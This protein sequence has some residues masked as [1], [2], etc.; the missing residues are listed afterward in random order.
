[1]SYIA[2]AWLSNFFYA[3]SIVVGKLSSKY[4]LRN[5]WLFNFVWTLVIVLGT[6]PFAI[7][8]GA[9]LPADWNSVFLVGIFSALAGTLYILSLY[10]L[11]ITVLVPLYSFRV[12]VSVLL[13]AV[14]FGER[15]ELWQ[16]WLIVLLTLAGLFVGMDER[17]RL[18]SFFRPEIVLVLTATVVSA[19]YGGTV[20]NA[21]QHNSYWE[22]ALWGNLLTQFFLLPTVPL[23][24]K[25]IRRTK[26]KVYR[27]PVLNGMLA[28]LGGL[29]AYKA[30]AENVGITAAIQTVPLSMIVTFALSLVAPQILEKH[31]PRVW[32]IRFTA[33]AVMVGAAIR[34]SL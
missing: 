17:L 30:L 28:A 4:Q 34:L 8:A 14:V 33:T 12:P 5:P 7:A 2:Y 29:A 19:I 26:L 18:R 25:D 11:D 23:F 13:G 22:T 16:V 24:W 32:A 6:T 3:T 9:G 31:L 10:K 21:M 20:K 1:M 27:G 15:V